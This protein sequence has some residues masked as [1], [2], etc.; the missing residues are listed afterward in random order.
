ML[1]EQKEELVK[2]FYS[3]FSDYKDNTLNKH[4]KKGSEIRGGLSSISNELNKKKSDCLDK[5]SVELSKVSLAPDVPCDYD[6]EYRHLLDYIP[7]KFSYGLIYNDDGLP[8]KLNN[9]ISEQANELPTKEVQAS[10][11]EY[12][13]YA[14]KY[15]EYC[16]DKI[17]V[18]SLRRNIQDNKSYSLSI[19]QLAILGL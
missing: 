5:M 11:R 19:G 16:V 9:G 13:G 15:M 18:D 3:L 8:V 14:R 1:K 6:S 17:K 2:G 12:N 10:M 7:N 4:S